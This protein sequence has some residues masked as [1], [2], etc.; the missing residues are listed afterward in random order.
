MAFGRRS[1]GTT[2]R[3]YTAAAGSCPLHR[4]QP[5]LN[6][7]QLAD[8]TPYLVALEAEMT[9][10][11]RQRIAP[12]GTPSSGLVAVERKAVDGSITYYRA[13]VVPVRD[14]RHVVFAIDYGRLGSARVSG[15][16]HAGCPCSADSGQQ[17]EPQARSRCTRLVNPSFMTLVSSEW[18]GPPPFAKVH[19]PTLLQTRF[20]C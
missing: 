12:A 20:R 3:W 15:D 4:S 16:T 11:Y 6:R 18:C 10:H 9:A 14:G 2:M 17:C 5:A 1:L 19:T 7:V 13:E 8:H